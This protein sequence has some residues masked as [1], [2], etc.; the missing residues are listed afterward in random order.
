MEVF[1]GRCSG[2]DLLK[3]GAA[4]VRYLAMAVTVVAIAAA[5]LV[6]GHSVVAHAMWISSSTSYYENPVVNEDAPDPGELADV[7]VILR[8]R[9]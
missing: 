6:L 5:Y 1:L 8:G 9:L 7:H 2:R 3:F 4:R